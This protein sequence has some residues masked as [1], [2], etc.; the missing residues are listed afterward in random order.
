[1][2]F[3]CLA[4]LMALTNTFRWKNQ[5]TIL[6]KQKI[7]ALPECVIVAACFIHFGDNS[8]VVVCLSVCLCSISWPYNNF[9]YTFITGRRLPVCFRYNTLTNY[10]L[11]KLPVLSLSSH[12]AILVLWS[13]NRKSQHDFIEHQLLPH[14]GFKV[15]SVWYWC[16]VSSGTDIYLL[17]D[18]RC[19]TIM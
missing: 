2:G 13:T 5:K 4:L 18:C 12:N 7:N 17:A 9:M 14:W 16:K 3:E 1:M 10:D 11:F 8:V 6:H 15:I 19:P